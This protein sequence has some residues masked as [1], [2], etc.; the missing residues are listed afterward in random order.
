MISKALALSQQEIQASKYV[1]QWLV[2]GMSIV[3]L[4]GFAIMIDVKPSSQEN[5]D[6]LFYCLILLL[7]TGALRIG[8]DFVF[9]VL[10][11]LGKKKYLIKS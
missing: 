7:V 1:L 3:V 5:L 11:H 2:L 9:T 6:L 8:Y 4:G 10:R